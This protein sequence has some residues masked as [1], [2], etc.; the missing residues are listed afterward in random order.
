MGNCPWHAHLAPTHV[1]GVVCVQSQTRQLPTCLRRNLIIS[2]QDLIRNVSTSSKRGLLT[3]VDTIWPGVIHAETVGMGLR[4]ARAIMS[5]ELTVMSLK[6]VME[7]CFLVVF[8]RILPNRKT[9]T[10]CIA[11]LFL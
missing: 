6:A 1:D 2:T 3:C 8:A 5:L 4:N 7:T 9:N 10:L 11:V